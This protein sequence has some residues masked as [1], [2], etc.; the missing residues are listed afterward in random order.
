[1]NLTADTGRLALSLDAGGELI[2]T[3]F[4]VPGRTY[5]LEETTDLESWTALFDVLANPGPTEVPLGP[6]E[7]N[8]MR[9]Y[10]AVLP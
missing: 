6:P 3:L 9:F 2:L 1:L 4:G 10:R 8:G 5:T 7:A